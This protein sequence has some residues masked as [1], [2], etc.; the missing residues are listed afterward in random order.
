[1]SR[2]LSLKESFTS[3]NKKRRCSSE[4]IASSALPL[5]SP[6]TSLPLISSSTTT[7]PSTPLAPTPSSSQVE[8]P[9]T[10]PITP[11]ILLLSTTVS[12]SS[13]S[14]KSQL[15][16]A[17]EEDHVSCLLPNISS[18]TIVAATSLIDMYD[19]NDI[20]ESLAIN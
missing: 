11:P 19:P 9:T 5:S 7:L 10:E 16:I 3:V 14:E 15:S 13:T 8:L 6:L 1:M 2:Q 18:N 17:D 4:D 20:G 12:L